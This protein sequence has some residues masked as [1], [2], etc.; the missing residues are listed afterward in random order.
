MV[1]ININ[2]TNINRTSYGQNLE[3][4][5]YCGC[6]SILSTLPNIIS[7]IT[8]LFLKEKKGLQ[9]QI[10]LLLCLSF[11]GI[12]I[13]FYPI[14]C[15]NYK[16]YI[17]QNS[18]SH[19]FLIISNYYQFIH[20]YIA[21]ILFMSPEKLSKCFIIFLIYIFPLF[22]FVS[23]FFIIKQNFN[24]NIYF[25]FIAYP[26]DDNN[27]YLKVILA[28]VRSL[29]FILNIFFIIKLKNQI[30]N[31]IIDTKYIDIKFARNKFNIYKKKLIQYIIVMI[32]VIHPYLFRY[33][34]RLFDKSKELLE[35]YIFEHYF[36][37]VECL[38]GLAFW[39]VYIYHKNFIGR[40]L[41][42]FC[43]KK[44]SEFTNE[45]L[46]EKKY[47]ENSAK[48]IFISNK[49]SNISMLNIFNDISGDKK[50]FSKNEINEAIAESLTDDET[51]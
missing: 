2:I 14:V 51:L 35:N 12:E 11:I 24:L 3:F 20:S 13:R 38:S 23:L 21:Y 34:W 4:Q 47:Y 28:I 37:G 27:E 17:F 45:F 22:L 40:F 48:S 50:I 5:I 18:F 15:Q 39:S 7:I 49:S 16:Y 8:I 43:C 26:S 41:I 19:S 25:N 1:N 36:H 10:Q 33:I 46:E 30:R 32:L 44:E 31:L 9:K 6:L 42:V 29:F